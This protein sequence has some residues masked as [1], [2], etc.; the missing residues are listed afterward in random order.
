MNPAFRAKA[1]HPSLTSRAFSGKIKR[2]DVRRFAPHPIVRGEMRDDEERANL[3]HVD[4]TR[5]WSASSF[6]ASTITFSSGM[7][8]KT[9]TDRPTNKLV[10]LDVSGTTRRL[11]FSF[12]FRAQA[13]VGEGEGTLLLHLAAR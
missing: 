9:L 6:H 8:L 1:T 2:V 3:S 7:A 10:M 4:A 12:E 11:E 5:W 13:Q